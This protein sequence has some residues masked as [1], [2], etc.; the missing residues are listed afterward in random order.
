[1]AVLTQVTIDRATGLNFTAEAAAGGGDS[2]TN[3]G[4]QFLYI[5]NGGGSPITLTV[6][7]QQQVDGLAVADKTYTIGAGEEWMIGPFPTATYNDSNG[8]VQLTYSGVTSVTV[9]PVKF[10]GL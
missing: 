3:D 10:E 9:K 7:T 8:R 1:M 2:F 4:K 6:V 5:K